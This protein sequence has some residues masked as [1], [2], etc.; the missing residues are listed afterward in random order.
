M[1]GQRRGEERTGA[2]KERKT[3]CGSVSKNK[4]ARWCAM[5][6]VSHTVR[7]S[8]ISAPGRFNAGGCDYDLS[9]KMR[10]GFSGDE[11]RE[12]KEQAA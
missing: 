4:L 12:Q 2:E 8:P 9:V 6:V 1:S 11:D 3:K 5:L 7:A 10:A